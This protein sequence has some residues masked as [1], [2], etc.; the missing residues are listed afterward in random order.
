MNGE[1]ITVTDTT[2][3]DDS[4][5][6]EARGTEIDGDRQFGTLPESLSDLLPVGLGVEVEVDRSSGSAVATRIEDL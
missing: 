2:L 4:L 1:T 6:E 5:I 3:I